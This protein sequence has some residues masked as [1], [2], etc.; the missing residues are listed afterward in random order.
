MKRKIN[1]C[2]KKV[3]VIFALLVLFA[4]TAFAYTYSSYG[5][6]ILNGSESSSWKTT[7]TSGNKLSSK[8]ES[9][10]S[11]Y[12]VYV[13]SKTMVTSPQFRI[14]DASNDTFCRY[15]SLTSVGANLEGD[16]NTASKGWTMYASLKPS[17]LQ[18]DSDTIKL[19]FSAD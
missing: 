16:E 6:F 9:D 2:T 19:K 8:K 4:Q 3:V 11:K 5:T 18:Y 13:S 1:S 14:V 12:H 7:T 15:I 10:S 17:A